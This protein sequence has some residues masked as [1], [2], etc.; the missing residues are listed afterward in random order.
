MTDTSPQYP[1][2]TPL[3]NAAIGAGQTYRFVHVNY[4][5][6]PRFLIAAMIALIVFARSVLGIK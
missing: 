1:R 2:Q 4:P 6:A 3:R 5:G